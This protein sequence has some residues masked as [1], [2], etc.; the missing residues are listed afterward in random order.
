MILG[1][2]GFPFDTGS[3][4]VRP[5][6][7]L[8]DFSPLSHRGSRPEFIA[9]SFRNVQAHLT[10]LSNQTSCP[11]VHIVFTHHLPHSLHTHLLF[12]GLHFE[13]RAN[14]LGGLIDI[15]RI[16][17][18]SVSQLASR[19][20][21]ATEDKHSALVASGGDEFLRHKV[22]AIVQRGYQTQI[23]GTVIGLDQI[24]AAPVKQLRISTPRSSPLAATNSFAT[25]F[26]PS[27]KEV[28]R[29]KSAAR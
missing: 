8:R 28:T 10:K 12:F 6:P 2:T 23:G 18:K 15:V 22:H 1:R 29:H 20:G 7:S 3:G 17:L 5:N 14:R 9:A 24:G 25:R 11:S 27:C 16:D 21:K 19:A 13:G 26:M 4:T